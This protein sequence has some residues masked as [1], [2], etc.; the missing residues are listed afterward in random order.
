[1]A[2]RTFDATVRHRFTARAIET[3]WLL[4]RTGARGPLTA[5]VTFPSWRG[6]VVAVDRDGQRQA[7][8]E[9]AGL[10]L[11]RVRWFE[12]QSAGAAYRID[13]LRYPAGATARISR[14]APQ[15]SNPQP[16]ETLTIRIASG[17]RWARA[18]LAARIVVDG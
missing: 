12:V 7:L 9:R 14:P 5:A 18:S 10:A 1:V 11:A 2:T 16:G 6:S 13:R 17:L 15:S 4:R 3:R 8:S